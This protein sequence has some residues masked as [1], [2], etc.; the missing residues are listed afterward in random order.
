[1]L[2]SRQRGPKRL[3]RDFPKET[4]RISSQDV[5]MTEVAATPISDSSPAAGARFR[6]HTSHW[7]V[8]SARWQDDELEVR[9]HPG[10][11]DPNRIIENFPGALRHRARVA[12]PM[13]RRGWLEGRRGPDATPRTRRVRSAVVG[14]GA[15]PARR[16]VGPRAGQSR[17][18]LGVRRLLR[19]VERGPLSPRAKPGPPLSQRRAWAAMSGRSTPT[20]PA[21]PRSCCPTSSATTSR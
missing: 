13:V 14:R 10:D 17:R 19:L 6:P 5:R 21:L 3:I 2:G 18:G 7:G 1:M 15:R 8:F 12:Q 4:P 11:P 9:P 16:R 20:A